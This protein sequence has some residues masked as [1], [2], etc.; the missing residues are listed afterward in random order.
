MQFKSWKYMFQA[1][2]NLNNIQEPRNKQN[3][4]NIS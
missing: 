1:I 3:L 2:E 4:E